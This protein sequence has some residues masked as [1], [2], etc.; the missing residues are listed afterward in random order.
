MSEHIHPPGQDPDMAFEDTVAWA[1]YQQ[2]MPLS[3]E[4]RKRWIQEHF[5]TV[6]E[7]GRIATVLNMYRQGGV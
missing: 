3:A 4:L 2:E 1:L 5:C 6:A 7:L